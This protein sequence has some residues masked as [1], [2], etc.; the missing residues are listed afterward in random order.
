MASTARRARASTVPMTGTQQTIGTQQMIG[1]QQTTG[2]LPMTGILQ[3][4]GR[5]NMEK[6][7]KASTAKEEKEKVSTAKRVRER[8]IQD[9][10]ED[11]IA[12]VDQER[13]RGA[14]ASIRGI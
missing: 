3:A 4:K 12:V 5:A 13:A 9:E 8:I 1:I 10:G 14:R 7:E 6:K 11:V 2:I